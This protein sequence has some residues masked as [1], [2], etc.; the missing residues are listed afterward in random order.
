M[1]DVN[2]HAAGQRQHINNQL[3]AA[4]HEGDPTWYHQSQLNHTEH[5]MHPDNQHQHGDHQMHHCGENGGEHHG[6]EAH[7]AHGGHEAHHSHHGHNPQHHLA[8]FKVSIE[9]NGDKVV[10]HKNRPT[11]LEIKQ[12]AIEQNVPIQLTF[13][14]QV[15]CANGTSDIVGD[16]DHVHL[17]PH[18]MFTAIAPDDN[19]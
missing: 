18:Q 3:G 16:T 9:L 19:S 11:G 2:Q 6:R 14:L 13:V 10:M 12:A 17:H 15:E 5:H 4:H 8:H 1:Q 7:Q